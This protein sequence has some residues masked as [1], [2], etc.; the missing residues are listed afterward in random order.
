MWMNHLD[1]MDDLREGIWLRGGKDQ[2]LSEYKKEAF[3]MFERLLGR[4][5]SEVAHTIFRIQIAQMA[6]PTLPKDVVEGKKVDFDPATAQPAAPTKPID[7]T[8]ALAAA[9]QKTASR[10]PK[11]DG[12]N[13]IVVQVGSTKDEPGRNDPCPCGA[14]NPSTNKP[15]KYKKCGLINASYHQA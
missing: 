10:A 4:I 5:S 9:M 12:R 6:Q 2:V 3:D 1:E 15:Y 11:A 13:P 7:S 8:G 14:V